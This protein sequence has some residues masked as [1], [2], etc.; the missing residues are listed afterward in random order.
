[1][2]IFH[3]KGL[4]A[5]I[6]GSLMFLFSPPVWT[7]EELLIQEIQVEGNV[8]VSTEEI[9]NAMGVKVGDPFSATKIEGGIEKLYA[10]GTFTEKP[11][12]EAEA[13]VEGVK[14]VLRVQEMPVLTRIL[15]QG[16]TVISTEELVKVISIP[17]GELLTR[18]KIEAGKERVD[19][20]YERRGFLA[21][22]VTGVGVNPQTGE[23]AFHILEGKI[24]AIQV[25]GNRRT[26]AW[27]VLSLIRSK[28]G[29]VLN[30]LQLEKDRYRVYGLGIFDAPPEWYAKPGSEDGLIVVVFRVSETKTGRFT[31]G[32]GYGETTGF[33]F[34]VALSEDN[35]KGRAQ[36]VGVSAA[37]G[38]RVNTFDIFYR[39]PLWN[40]RENTVETRA[41]RQ[42]NI[43]EIRSTQQGN[44]LST[45][46]S[47]ETG[48]TLTYI[49]PVH[50]IYYYTIALS[51]REQM[52]NL[53]SG[54]DL[55][56]TDPEAFRRAGLEE[57]RIDS[58]SLS[59]ARDT[60]LN[61]YDPF[62]GT[63]IDAGYT[64]GFKAIG[65]DFGYNQF[66]AGY[67]TYYPLD[68]KEKFVFAW[69]LK[70]GST[71]GKVPAV[72]QFYV[73]GTD[74]VRGYEFGRLRGDKMGLFNAEVRYRGQPIGAVIF[75]DAG[76][77]SA[78][79][80]HFQIQDTIYSI[81]AGIR[82]KIPQL[83]GLPIRLDFGYNF[84]RD[85]IRFHFGFG[86]LF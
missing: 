11:T 41:F 61:I 23:L 20:E 28:A 38:P 81:G 8:R 45:Y 1:M 50:D 14:I 63:R 55:K 31:F 52:L 29:D 7:Q 42:E 49:L 33:S 66:T 72:E 58:L 10:L 54:Q 39:N 85:E 18:Q 83:S 70:G 15:I 59:W 86:Q 16:N 3:R 30:A 37:T 68:R 2:R 82:L 44:P 5:G 60:R 67:R 40:Q 27:V 57:G 19:K 4:I 78:I 62:Q 36:K 76:D 25:E 35:F 21:S 17:A 53:F 84:E 22:Q 64:L 69:R 65:A 26:K 46:T 24:E 73:G 75:F 34:S 13:V 74:T 79:G 43:L 51:S 71:Y 56:Q 32:A 12:Y 9:L 6:F 77:A 80:K 48:G 47:I